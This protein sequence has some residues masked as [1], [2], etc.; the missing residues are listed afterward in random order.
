LTKYA[1]AV[2][3]ALLYLVFMLNMAWHFINELRWRKSDH[4]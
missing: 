4:E 1:I 2:I 3:D